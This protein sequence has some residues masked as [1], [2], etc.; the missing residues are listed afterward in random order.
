MPH[1]H[2]LYDFVVSIFIVNR[3]RVLL[4]WHKKYREWLP[5]GG[6]VDLDEDPDHALMKEIREE[7]GLEVKVLSD[8]PAMA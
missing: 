3:G 6:H 4:C 7:C 8:R 5:I 2:R 1:I